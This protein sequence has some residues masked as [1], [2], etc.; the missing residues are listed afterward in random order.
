MDRRNLKKRR[1]LILAVVLILFILIWQLPEIL[2]AIPSRYV[3][4]YLPEPV[5]SLA[6]REHVEILPT[7]VVSSDANEVLEFDVLVRESQINE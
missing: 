1:Y 2:K 3:A 6:V 4:A 7:A 5:Q